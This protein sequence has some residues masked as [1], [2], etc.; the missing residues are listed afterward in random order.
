M[1]GTQLRLL[2]V[3]PLA[4]ACSILRPDCGLAASGCSFLNQVT[5][6]SGFPPAEWQL[7]WYSWP[8]RAVFARE[9]GAIVG[10]C[11]GTISCKAEKRGEEKNWWLVS[12]FLSV[13]VLARE[14]AIV[15]NGE[16]SQQ[17]VAC[18]LTNGLP[19][20]DFACSLKMSR[21]G[22]AEKKEVRRRAVSQPAS[23]LDLQFAARRFL[24][25]SY[26][27]GAPSDRRQQVE[28]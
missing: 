18:G 19:K 10:G 13:I 23:R 17:L 7:S 16:P 1:V 21:S 22:S 8:S 27:N 2:V 28:S 4:R 26:A 24:G 6:G 25:R 12:V 3:L 14:E 9:L 20:A 5:L 15:F 11:G